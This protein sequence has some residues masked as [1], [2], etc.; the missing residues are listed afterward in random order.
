MHAT[1]DHTA[2]KCHNRN[3]QMD[4]NSELKQ[5]AM[6]WWNAVNDNN[7]LGSSR[8]NKKEGGG[9]LSSDHGLKIALVV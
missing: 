8:E 3:L 1:G 6:H 5:A 9:L 2:M 4:Q 7:A